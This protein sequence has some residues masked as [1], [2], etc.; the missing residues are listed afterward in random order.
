MSKRFTLSL[1]D[2]SRGLRLVLLFPGRDRLGENAQFFARISMT[3]PEAEMY[4]G[5]RIARALNITETHFYRL[6]FAI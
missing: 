6:G 2:K 4:S 5:T 1:L 3:L